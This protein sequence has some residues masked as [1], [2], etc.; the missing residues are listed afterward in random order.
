MNLRQQ[1]RKLISRPLLWAPLLGWPLAVLVVLVGRRLLVPDEGAVLGAVEL[2]LALSATA[3][4]AVLTVL[5]VRFRRD[6]RDVCDHLFDGNYEAAFDATRRNAA[7][8]LGLRLE[9]ALEKLLEFDR[10]R[11][12]RVATATRLLDC[13][14]RE[15]PLPILVGDL[16]A[17]HIRLS[18][19]L[20]EQCHIDDDRFPL[21]AILHP[22]ANRQFAGL[23]RRLAKGQEDILDAAVTLHL[24]VRRAACELRFRLLAVHN[25]KGKTA[26]ILGIAQP[27]EA[28][29]N[30]R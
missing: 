11:A 23:W 17:D 29:Q 21:H 24:P 15:V 27:P 3:V 12:E 18:R 28:E 20:C 19:A 6:L 22:P 25:E 16:E 26:Y 2:V 13:L 9:K 1:W 8:A 4:L 30:T 7:L 10:R 5:T 14:L